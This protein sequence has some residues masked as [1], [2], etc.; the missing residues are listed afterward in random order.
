MSEHVTVEVADGVCRIRLQR[1][2]KKNAIDRAMYGALAAALREADGD[3]TVGCILFAGVP[4]AFS[5]GNDIADF[6]GF[7]D[8]ERPMAELVD[9]LET[10]AAVAKPM[11][12]A[13]DGLAIGI[14][15]TLLLHCDLVYAT[16]RSIFR[17]PFSDLGLVPEAASSLL[18]PLAMGHQRAFALLVMGETWDADTALAAGLIYAVGESAE[19]DAQTAARRIAAKPRE[20]VRIGRALLRTAPDAVRARIAEEADHFRD[21]LRSPEA[22]AAFAAFLKRG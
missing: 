20:A 16:P 9:F 7:A 3:E 4:G 10:L 6:A 21:R 18:G 1:A 5:A 12:A 15:T 11:V 19:G 14:G 22:Q 13:V 2:D 8:A 17:T